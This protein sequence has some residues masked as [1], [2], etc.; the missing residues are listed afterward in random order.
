[1]TTTSDFDEMNGNNTIL[2]AMASL[3]E[4]I[5]QEISR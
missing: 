4:E 5:E 3:K 1:M 2:F